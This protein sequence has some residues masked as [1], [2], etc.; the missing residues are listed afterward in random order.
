MCAKNNLCHK[1]AALGQNN[2]WAK[3]TFGPK[4]SYFEQKIILDIKETTL[5]KNMWGQKK[6]ILWSLDWKNMLGQKDA[7]HPIEVIFCHTWLMV[8]DATVSCNH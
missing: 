4:R 7:T 1:E 3:T 8:R 6:R 2:I 5:G